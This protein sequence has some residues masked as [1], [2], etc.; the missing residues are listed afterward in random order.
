MADDDKSQLEGA[1]NT[2]LQITEKS[3]NLR[4]DLKEDIVESESTLRNIFIN[5]KN[6][7]E[8]QNKEIN[9]L[10][11]ELNKAKEELRNSRIANLPGR[12]TPSRNGIGQ[13]PE[14]SLHCQLPPSDG[15]RKL[16]S[17]AVCTSTDKRFKLLVKSKS[18]FSTEAIKMVVKTNINPTAMKVGVKS[19]MSLKDGRVL[20][21]IGTPE[22]VNL[23]SSSIRDKCGNDLEVTVPKLRNPRMV[24]Y[25]VPQDINLENLEETILS[26]NPELGLILGDIVAKFS[27]RTK[28]GLV[29]MFIEV[30]SGTRKKLLHKKLK[31][32][33]LICNTDD[34]LVVRRCFKCSR[35][36]HRHQG[37]RGEETCPLCAGAH[38]LKECTAPAAQYKCINCETFSRYTRGEKNK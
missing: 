1:L 27:Y 4:R 7:G 26:Q 28:R 2:L 38:K 31:L 6:R 36:N 14:G 5:L 34:Y 37:C 15:A 23:I 10:E 12:A 25:N 33:W 3:G 20:I 19:F 18:N 11:G 8:E 35:F 29:N 21:E 16:Y 24:I 32:G 17:E 9:R 22:E 13:T 30:C